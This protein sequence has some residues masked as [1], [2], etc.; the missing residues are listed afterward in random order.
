MQLLV[1]EVTR[2]SH[3]EMHRLSQFSYRGLTR[4][5]TYT[6]ACCC[7]FALVAWEYRVPE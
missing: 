4:N 6:N 7:G 1:G 3:I 2:L 5:S